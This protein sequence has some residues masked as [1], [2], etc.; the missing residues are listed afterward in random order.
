[1][2]TQSG[3][4]VPVTLVRPCVGQLGLVNLTEFYEPA[5]GSLVKVMSANWN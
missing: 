5:L 4:N 1:M 2:V 3:V